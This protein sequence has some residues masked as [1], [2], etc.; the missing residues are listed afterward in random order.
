MAAAATLAAAAARAQAPG[1]RLPK[2]SPGTLDIHH[3]NTGRGNAIFFVL[4]DGTTLL[5]DAGDGGSMPPRGTPQRPDASRT[6]AEW[7]APYVEAL[8]VR[9]IATATLPTS[10]TTT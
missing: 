10:T 1:E 4:P 3:I 9:A 6:P 8:G 7:I 2:W 5:L